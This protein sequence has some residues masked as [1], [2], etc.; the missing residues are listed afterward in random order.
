MQL[1]GGQLSEAAEAGDARVFADA[2]QGDALG[3]NSQIGQVP[4]GPYIAR[5]R[6]PGALPVNVCQ[7]GLDLT[8][9]QAITQ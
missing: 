2:D 6:P 5:P 9:S 4:G 3:G 1:P 8:R 7:F